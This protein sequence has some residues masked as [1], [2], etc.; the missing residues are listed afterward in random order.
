MTVRLSTLR[1]A[2][3]LPSGRNL[4]LIS[5]RGW[6]EPRAIMRLEGLRKLKKS[7]DLIGNQ[8]SNLP[9]CSIVLQPTML[10]RSLQPYNPTIHLLFS[11]S[12]YICHQLTPWNWV[13]LEK[14]TVA[15]LLRISQH[16]MEAES[17]L[18]CS[19]NPAS[20]PNPEPDKSFHTTQSY[21]PTIHPNI[22]L[23]SIFYSS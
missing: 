10:L 17:W 21:L 2:R 12:L 7:D 19:Q 23:Q 9:T 3:P 18:L 15:H 11:I 20:G 8:T 22:I 14:L 1:A 13:L 6:F 16:F 5:V 4:V